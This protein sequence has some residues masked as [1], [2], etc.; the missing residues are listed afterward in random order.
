MK[1]KETALVKL[2]KEAAMVVNG[3][4]HVVDATNSIL[5]KPVKR[6]SACH[7][8]YRLRKVVVLAFE[9]HRCE[10][11]AAASINEPGITGRTVLSTVV[12]DALA[13]LERLER[14]TGLVRAA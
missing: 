13:R 6:A 11:L 7:I 1:S 3:G 9:A 12:L 4:L 5:R 8:K 10:E 14:F 2:S